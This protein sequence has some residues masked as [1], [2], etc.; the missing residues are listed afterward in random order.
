MKESAC[1]YPE[2]ST[3]S[4]FSLKHPNVAGI[5]NNPRIATY[6]TPTRHR[7]NPFGMANCSI[8]GCLATKFIAERET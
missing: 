7:L 3:C 8:A 5:C 2:S 4:D 1:R 6:P